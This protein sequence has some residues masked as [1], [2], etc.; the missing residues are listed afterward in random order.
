MDLAA[1]T[2]WVLLFLLSTL[3]VPALAEDPFPTYPELRGN[4]E[5][6]EKVFGTWS[7]EQVAVHDLDYPQVIYEVVDLPGKIETRYSKHQKDFLKSTQDRWRSRLE[8]L[9]ASVGDGTPLTDEQK[10]WALRLT[11]AGGHDAV[12]D[13][14]L[15]I[16]TQRGMRERFMRGLEISY[17]Y[18]DIFRKIFRDAGLPEDIAYLPHVE[19]SFQWTARSSAN[20]VGLWQFTRG[21]GR[22]FMTISAAYDERLDPVSA[23]HGAAAYL[24]DA[25]SRIGN[26]PLALTAYNHGVGGIQ[27]A[28]GQHGDDYVTIFREYR[29]RLFGFASKNFYSEFLAAR[30]VAQ[31]AEEF[32]PEGHSP[33]PEFNL[34]S[35]VLETRTNV[36]RLATAFGFSSDELAAINPAWTRHATQ[37][38]YTLPKD[39]TVWLPTGTLAELQ[40][41]GVDPD[42]RMAATDNDV[43]IVQPGDNLTDIATAHGM[44]LATLRQLN[45]LP[46]SKSLIR[47]GQKL[48]VGGKGTSTA[49]VVRSGDTLSRI[50]SRY[51]IRLTE[52]R[53][54]NGIPRGSSLIRAGQKLRVG[55]GSARVHVV[56]SGDSLIRI[57]FRHGVRLQ[58]LLNVN[59]L[60]ESS[61][62]HPGER[63][64]LPG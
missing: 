57:A 16:R 50:A 35:I 34:D 28:Q 64:R 48:L 15:R 62:I 12:L 42:Y 27:R 37:S 29:G 56:R 30:N 7:M 45:G 23:A 41:R 55:G 11:E 63:L 25:H 59:G 22:R 5:F 4:V 60:T 31:R 19:S 44:S 18:D 39:S 14:A 13:A 36:S 54:M 47:V 2:R 32:F 38:G 6:W 49:H 20:A 8:T 3:F 61:V 58:E 1:R 9:S 26:W 10:E 43:Y 24:A 40:Q 21:A 33:E 51:G 53:A 46:R 52:L 17:R